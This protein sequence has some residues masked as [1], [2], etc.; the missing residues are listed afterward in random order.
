MTGSDW[1]PPPLPP[2]HVQQLKNLGLLWVNIYWSLEQ[3]TEETD[4][5]SV[6]VGQSILK[7]IKVQQRRLRQLQGKK[8]WRHFDGPASFMNP[9]MLICKNF[10]VLLQSF[11]QLR[12]SENDTLKELTKDSVVYFMPVINQR[13]QWLSSKAWR[14]VERWQWCSL[15]KYITLYLM[16]FCFYHLPKNLAFW[17]M[18]NNLFSPWKYTNCM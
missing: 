18:L 8:Y 2:E 5:L 15:L 11:H 17:K 7:F 14:G 12:K 16:H 13:A 4:W 10:L 1:S 3:H 6:L 9:R